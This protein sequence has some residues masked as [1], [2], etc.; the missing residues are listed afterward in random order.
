VSGQ[1]VIEQ[2]LP[3]EVVDDGSTFPIR[4]EWDTTDTTD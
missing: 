1:G 2:S 4:L 3:F